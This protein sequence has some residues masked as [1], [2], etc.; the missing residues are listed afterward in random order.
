MRLKGKAISTDGTMVGSTNT[1]SST[2]AKIQD[3]PFNNQVDPLFIN[4]PEVLKLQRA[5]AQFPQGTELDLEVRY[6][7]DSRDCTPY[8]MAPGD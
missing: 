3:L 4:D 7:S 1:S 6:T 5:M 8:I 2:K